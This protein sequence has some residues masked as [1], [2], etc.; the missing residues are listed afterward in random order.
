[1]TNSATKKTIENH[2]CSQLPKNPFV[3]NSKVYRLKRA[4]PLNNV[5][6][7]QHQ[8]LYDFYNCLWG[9]LKEKR[10]E[11]CKKN[12]KRRMEYQRQ[13]RA[14]K[15][16]PKEFSSVLYDGICD[17]N[18]EAC[19]Y[20]DCI[21]P[22]WESKKEYDALYYQK[23]RMV[24]LQRVREWRVS[25]KDERKEYDSEYRKKHKKEIAA[26]RKEYEDRNREHI[27]AQRHKYYEEHKEEI[28]AKQRQY[29][30]KNRERIKVQKHKY[31][32]EHKESNIPSVPQP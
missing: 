4:R 32:E 30:A 14:K 18:C 13:Y 12:H 29:N 26:K 16:P 19:L 28:L 25:H 1:M 15:N 6:I 8:K 21:L 23:N 9:D 20:D 2:I 5:E 7:R 17:L 3:P 31:Y 10:S 11:Y 22:T 27:K 24:K